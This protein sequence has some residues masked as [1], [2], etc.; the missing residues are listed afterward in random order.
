M[1]KYLAIAEHMKHTDSV[2]AG[3]MFGAKC[4]KIGGKAYA[5]FHKGKMVFKL[6]PDT[7]P[8]LFELEGVRMFEPMAGG[9]QMNGWVEVPAIYADRWEPLAYDALRYVRSLLEK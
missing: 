1:E 7:F 4:L 9:R 8:A 5:M 2:A 6:P 3:S